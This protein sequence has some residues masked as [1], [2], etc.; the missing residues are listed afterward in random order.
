MI[1]AELRQRM[2][3][4]DLRRK[5]GQLFCCGFE[6]TE[7]SDN[8]KQLIEEYHVGGIIYFARNVASVDQVTNLSYGLQRIAE[9]SGNLPLW[10][11]I[12]QEGGMVARITEGVALMPGN[13]AVAAAG[14][15]ES[16]YEAAFITGQELLAMG[17]NLNLAPVLDVNN[18]ALNPV[19]GVRSYSESPEMVAE[20]GV[21]A[22]RGFQA[23]GVTATAKHFPGHGD[24]DTDSHLDLPTIRHDRERIE[25]VELVPFRCAIEA[26]LDAIMSSHIYFPALEPRKLPT[27]LS[28]SLL[29]GLLR[30]EL[31]FEGVIMTDCMEMKA[32]KDHYGT[33]DA[34]VMAVE[35]GADLLLISHTFDLQTRAIDALYQAV[36]EG[37][38]SID[39]I[40]ASVR[41]VLAYKAKRGILN[42]DTP[43]P[44]AAFAIGSGDHL[45]A[46]RRISESSVTLVRDDEGLLPLRRERTLVVTIATTVTSVA[47]ESLGSRRSL[48]EAL[49]LQGLEVDDRVMLPDAVSSLLDHVVEEARDEKIK[50]IVIGTYNAQ[51]HASQ[52]EAVNR[53][54]KLGKPLIVA[55]LR[56]PYDILKLPE[57]SAYIAAYESRPLALES[58]AKAMM[59]IIPFRGRLPVS[60]GENYPIGWGVTRP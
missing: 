13:M 27:T 30:G 1:E 23:A 22:V 32:I 16:A 38:I 53:L 44:A 57:T 10:I 41:R 43:D 11:S 2:E 24:T 15:P 48:G 5:I 6:G 33:V 34:V 7:P 58:T 49:A 54:N 25:R 14:R 21:Q 51:F 18:N 39:R 52:L 17:I 60:L 20:Y 45:E 19:I 29:T 9:E 3:G 55:A 31:G 35:A 56:N 4:M 28:Y 42:A 46:A 50:Q 40:D 47:D 12:D 8:I 36:Q 37:R 59:G 26:G